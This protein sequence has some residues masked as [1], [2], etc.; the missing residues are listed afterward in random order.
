MQYLPWHLSIAIK[1]LSEIVIASKDGIA[2]VQLSQYI[3]TVYLEH[4]GLPGSV[5]CRTH[6]H[7]LGEWDRQLSTLWA[8]TQN[9]GFQSN[10]KF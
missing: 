10:F 6:E 4:V 2:A 1:L 5:I 7:M 8:P 9:G 3:W